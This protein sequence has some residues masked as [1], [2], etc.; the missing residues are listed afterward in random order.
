MLLAA[1]GI[2]LAGVAVI[3]IARTLPVAFAAET[4]IG[5]GVGMGLSTGAV[6]IAK[7]FVERLRAVVFLATDCA[8]SAA[9]YVFPS[10][11]GLALAAGWRWQS[12]YLLVCV[13]PAAIALLC[14]RVRFPDLAAD[15]GSASAAATRSVP[16]RIPYLRVALFGAAL[17]MYLAGQNVFTIWAPAYLHAQWG[18][19]AQRSGEIVGTFFGA[20]S[21]GLIAAA[22]LVTRLPPRAVLLGSLVLATTLTLLLSG[23]ATPAAFFALTIG[24]GFCSTAM[25]KLL[26]SIGSEQMPDSP[27]RLVTF[28]IVCT[29]AGGIVAPALSAA[30]VKAFALHASLYLCAAAYA[31]TLAIVVVAFLVERR[32]AAARPIP[33]A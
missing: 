24:F 14:L 1:S 8:F 7:R 4:A 6:I 22:L 11:V 19:P 25:F 30:V 28:L 2:V 27:A 23:A 33:A 17:A 12:G 20:S 13:I 18:L 16:A 9:G 29:D 10:I 21:F 32:A 15:R 31:T 26:I 5:L 3:C